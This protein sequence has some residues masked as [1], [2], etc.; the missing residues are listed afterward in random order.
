MLTKIREVTSGWFAI[1]ILGFIS[2]L[3]ALWGINGYFQGSAD[4]YAAR[5]TLQPGWFG[6]GIGAKYKDIS[7]EQYR[8]AYERERQQQ[9]EQ[10]GAR[11]DQAVF[12]SAANKREVM[13]HLVQREL[14]I[15]SAKRDGLVIPAGQIK[16]AILAM[17]A[18]QVEGKFDL[19]RYQALL[20][21]Q[22]PPMTG[23]QFEANIREDEMV[24]ALPVELAASGISSDVDVD[25]FV[26]LS[27]QT[28]N[29]LYVDVV[30]QNAATP[31]GDAELQAWYKAHVA[32]YRT[33]EQVA[34]E[35]LELDA[36]TLQVPTTVDDAT[37]KAR[38][39]D[40]KNR[41]VEP[42]QRLASHILINVPANASPAVDKA[43]QAKAA[44]L[45]AQA[46][47]PGA[48]FAALAK[49]NSQDEGSKNL[50]GDLGWLTEKVIDQKTFAAALFALKPGQVSDP[51][52]SSEGWHVILLRDVRAG[53]QIPF[54]T[55]RAELE[56]SELKDQRE[57]LYNDL[58][59]K[60]VDLTLKDP[61]SLAPAARA[62]G[63]TIQKTPAFGRSG[64]AGIAAN[65]K[66]VKAAF[67][68]SVLEDGNSSDPI[69]LGDKPDHMVI[70]RVAEHDP[71]KTLPFAQVRVRVI[72]DVLA[73]RRAKAA[74]AAADA[75][76]ARAD[77]GEALGALVPVGSAV[78]TATAV[79]R[80]QATLPHPLLEAAFRLP[81]PVAG[82]PLQTGLAQIAP[83]H[84]A[85][86][87]VTGVV[88]G[89][90]KLVD[91]DTRAN[92]R[93][94]AAQARAAVETKAYLDA[95]K[96]QFQVKIAEDRL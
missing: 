4:T 83:D 96:R 38:Y 16:S 55:V 19:A 62:M 18:F 54:E 39:E 91:A 85:L 49:A 7:V 76:L 40:E 14:L 95:L 29:L 67:S 22:N 43:A 34:L 89:D 3:F 66:V 84:Y 80:D 64:G 90:P 45:A 73:D 31:P 26:R 59:G 68:A 50:G 1:V 51:V 32:D 60:I 70:I 11:F 92:L 75:L 21:E 82:K 30:A 37:L 46:R 17:P 72:V 6:T 81:H 10:L 2:A 52:R 8:Q 93:R 24:R 36:A 15:A 87:Q 42:E 74:K 79:T 65:P 86:V 71:V 5:I 9:R 48:D 12:E 57:K 27:R 13:D 23:P 20:G 25:A 41:Y 33:Q 53:K 78:Q 58:S 69:E 63:L 61:T 56:K 77:K 44:E 47:K 88:D 28:R 35:Y 94:Q